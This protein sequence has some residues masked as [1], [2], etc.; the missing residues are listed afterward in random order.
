MIRAGLLIAMVGIG[1]L[2]GCFQADVGNLPDIN[3]GGP[4]RQ[5][6]DSSRVPKTTTLSDCQSELQKAYG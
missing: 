2:G 3:V 4:P 1:L 6:V 5:Q